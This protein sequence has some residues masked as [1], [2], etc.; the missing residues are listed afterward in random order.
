MSSTITKE[1]DV[2]EKTTFSFPTIHV[3]YTVL[4]ATPE[5]PMEL[6]YASG[7]FDALVSETVE[8]INY[9]DGRSSLALESGDQ[10]HIS[11]MKS[12]EKEFT[13][14]HARQVVAG[15]DH[16]WT[17][18]VASRRP[19]HPGKESAIAVDATGRVGVSHWRDDSVP[20]EGQTIPPFVGTR[21]LLVSSSSGKGW[22]DQLQ[23]EWNIGSNHTTYPMLDSSLAYDRSDR[24][25]LA[26]VR[27]LNGDP[28]NAFMSGLYYTVEGRKKSWDQPIVPLAVPSPS[29]NLLSV[30]HA[31]I[32]LDASDHYHI[33]YTTWER[34]TTTLTKC[35]VRYLT[36]AD[37]APERALIAELSEDYIT[38]DGVSTLSICAAPPLNRT[39]I[40]IDPTDTVHL[41]Y[42]DNG[43]TKE[44]LEDHGL[45]Y[46]RRQP[47][48]NWERQLVDGRLVH[49][50]SI[51]VSQLGDV[52]IA[53][54]E[55][56]VDHTN[57]KFALGLKGQ[58]WRLGYIQD[59]PAL[60]KLGDVAVSGSRGRSNRLRSK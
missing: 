32:A 2:T 42:W 16:R 5:F 29:S 21:E 36:N 35:F 57:L 44:Y 3:S 52:I 45:W 14:R 51:A 18:E 9:G 28:Q 15:K 25:H 20:M 26:Y 48:G 6:R 19:I 58:P 38:K 39:A 53:Y 33:I 31:Q 47:G 49:D 40:A 17:T 10:P 60:I 30:S 24:G 4:M 27:T 56:V 50:V 22:S 46:A 7:Q 59:E 55:P 12:E 43:T 41:A 37:D 13:L 1:N 34:A 54:A 23:K 11:Y 8:P